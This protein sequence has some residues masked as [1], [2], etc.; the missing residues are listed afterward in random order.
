M[1]DT[2]RVGRSVVRLGLSAQLVAGC[3]SGLQG[4]LNV[5]GHNFAPAVSVS[6][7]N[8]CKALSAKLSQHP[9]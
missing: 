3:V 1:R 9:G 4:R 6:P 8:S 5:H 2:L 7:S